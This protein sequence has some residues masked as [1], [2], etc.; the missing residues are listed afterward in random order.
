MGKNSIKTDKEGIEDGKNKKN[1]LSGVEKI[2]NLLGGSLPFA[3]PEKGEGVD[4]ARR[5]F[6]N[7]TNVTH[8]NEYIIYYIKNRSFLY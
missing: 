3:V 5:P 7:V 1:C 4:A 8:A 2:K 6:A